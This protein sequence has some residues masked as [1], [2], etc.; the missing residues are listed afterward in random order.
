MFRI[1]TE[2]ISE[3]VKQKIFFLLFL[4]ITITSVHVGVL[5]RTEL[6][7][8]KPRRMRFPFLKKKENKEKKEE[9]KKKKCVTRQYNGKRAVAQPPFGFRGSNPLPLPKKR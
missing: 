7:I 2:H 9:K 3:R 6:R 8:G 5:Q 1:K 4:Q